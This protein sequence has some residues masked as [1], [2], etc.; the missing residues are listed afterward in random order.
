MSEPKSDFVKGAFGALPDEPFIDGTE[1]SVPSMGEG[2]PCERENCPGPMG[3]EM[4]YGLAGGGC[5]VYHY[6]GVCGE[7]KDK[8]QDAT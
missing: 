3:W 7:V 6:C 1:Q 5:G 4:G 8:A 2:K